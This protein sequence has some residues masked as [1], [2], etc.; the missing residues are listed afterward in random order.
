[1]E[2]SSARFARR[3]QKGIAHLA[4]LFIIV[5]L[6]IGVA[7]WFLTSKQELKLPQPAQ[8]STQDK[9]VS[10]KPKPFKDVSAD[11]KNY[12][13]IK[14][15]AREGI[16]EADDSG[17]FNPRSILT[18]SEWAAVLVKLSGADPD[19][20]SYKDCFTDVSGHRHEAAVCYAK[21]QG[22]LNGSSKEQSS[23][24]NFVQTVQAQQTKESFNPNQLAKDAEAAGSLSRVMEWTPG[25]KL[26]DEQ[27]LSLAK[28]KNLLDTTGQLTKGGAAELA[29]RS[30][31]TVPFGQEKYT[32]KADEAVSR[33]K[34]GYLMDSQRISR[35]AQ[36]SGEWVRTR[37]SAIRNF[38]EGSGIGYKAATEIVDSSKNRDEALKKVREYRYDQWLTKR[39]SDGKT[40]EQADIFKAAQ[41]FVNARGGQQQ[42]TLDDVSLSKR[43]DPEA[44]KLDTSDT[45]FS[46]GQSI[47]MIIPL[48]KDYQMLTLDQR[49]GGEKV[50]YMLDISAGDMFLWDD[51]NQGFVFA[52]VIN[53]ETGVIEEAN[54]SK[55]G[56]FKSIDKMLVE[57]VD[58]VESRLG[59]K[60]TPP[61]SKGEVTPTSDN[62]EP[63]LDIQ[64]KADCNKTRARSSYNCLIGWTKCYY[65]CTDRTKDVSACYKTCKQSEDACDKQVE[66][67]YKAC[68]A[69]GPKEET[70][71][72]TK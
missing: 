29:Y 54:Y 68:L 47:S 66:A 72:P 1:M 28:E 6:V 42:L 27:A 3:A 71:A 15:L 21:E 65:P 22:W 69:A 44:D 18:R 2:E 25:Q 57:A 43:S 7:V 8:I 41:Q 63:G 36:A 46:E 58:R 48:D 12:S 39:T 50:K 70:Q 51:Q 10:L 49:K 17:N 11:N 19:I 56:N 32:P 38:A 9:I 26:T 61:G 5:L 34:A 30:L 33:Q 20:K 24:F 35:E 4:L 53:I 14:Y 16:L 23:I 64:T 60:L 67:E 52:E 13:A 59:R 37:D 40:L 31:A 55:D 62:K 45:T